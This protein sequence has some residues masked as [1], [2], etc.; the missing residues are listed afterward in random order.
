MDVLIV[1]SGPCGAAAARQLSEIAPNLK[2]LLVECGPQL[3]PNPGQNVKNIADPR[4]REAAQVAS[5][6]SSAM[7]YRN[8][9]VAQRAAE[10]LKDGEGE[11]SFLARPGT[12]LVSNRV[13]GSTRIGMPAAS[14]STNV[15]GMGAHWTCACPRPDGSERIPF[16]PQPEQEILL[17]RADELLNVSLEAY[18]RSP[19]GDAILRVLTSVFDRSGTNERHVAPMPLA[20]KVLGTGA[21]YW[22]G[23]DI[24]L[25]QLADPTTRP[26]NFELRSRTLCRRLLPEGGVIRAVVLEDLITGDTYEVSAKAVFVAAD[27]FRTPQILWASG[28]RPTA[29]GHYLNDQPQVLGAVH[30]N[31]QALGQAGP[32]KSIKTSPDATVGVFWVPFRDVTHPFHGQVMHMDTSPIQFESAERP[33]AK[34]IVGLGWFTAKDI[35][36]DDCVTFSETENDDFGMPRMQIHYR[37]T[38]KDVLSIE[39]AKQ[40][41]RRAAAALGELVDPE[42]PRQIPSGSSLHYQGTVRMGQQDDGTS[43]CDPESRVW[44]LRNLY[45]GGNGVI[46]TATACNPTLTS[47]ALA[48]KAVAAIAREF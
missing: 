35:R 12:H 30:L 34:H 13:Y 31:A 8:P 39:L 18:P 4:E 22:T 15:G 28:I 37:L 3:T 7:P 21:R 44:G 23:S 41:V 6:A 14:M 5:Q 45:V 17:A 25:G 46:P 48:V 32:G 20:C 1:G 47:V 38:D 43:V 10:P 11:T 2:L 24:V 29:L 16:L 9:S 36:F 33:D 19:A 26:S 40:A 27:A 42:E